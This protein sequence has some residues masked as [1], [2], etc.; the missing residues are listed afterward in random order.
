MLF[1]YWRQ[2]LGIFEENIFRKNIMQAFTQ[3]LRNNNFPNYVVRARAQ[4]KNTEILKF[5]IEADGNNY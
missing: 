3:A 4:N 2:H 1:K 5:T